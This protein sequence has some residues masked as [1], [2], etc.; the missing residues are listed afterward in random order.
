M[1]KLENTYIS[2]GGDFISN[3]RPNKEPV[4]DNGWREL[5]HID[6]N[7]FIATTMNGILAGPQFMGA[8]SSYIDSGYYQPYSGYVSQFQLYGNYYDVDS[9]N[10]GI[11]TTTFA[12]DNPNYYLAHIQIAP[13]MIFGNVWYGVQELA[14]YDNLTA[15]FNGKTY[16]SSAALFS[17]VDTYFKERIMPL[18][19]GD[20]NFSLND[21]WY[22]LN[23]QSTYFHEIEDNDINYHRNF[24]S[25]YNV[26]QSVAETPIEVLDWH[27]DPETEEEWQAPWQ[28]VEMNDGSPVARRSF[29]QPFT[30]NLLMKNDANT[31]T[32]ISSYFN[33]YGWSIGSQYITSAEDI[34]NKGNSGAFTRLNFCTF[35]TTQ[36]E[37]QDWVPTNSSTFP[38]ITYTGR[39]EGA[40]WTQ[41]GTIDAD[42]MIGFFLY[43]GFEVADFGISGCY[44]DDPSANGMLDKLMNRSYSGN[45]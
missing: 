4:L 13:H 29:I 34:Y 24:A 30:V 8:N 23:V 12:S 5:Y 18:A 44:V 38:T 22:K 19:I 11:Y 28:Y 36:I 26:D 10:L 15:R 25:V 6:H 7:T 17:A 41:T 39:P 16:Y 3:W 43:K 32:L 9:A 42:R 2:F 45:V 37:T 31:N 40:S 33:G 20:F 21:T 27:Y 1:L 35:N 14:W